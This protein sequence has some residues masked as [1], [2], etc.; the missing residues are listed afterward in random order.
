MRLRE[1]AQPGRVPSSLTRSRKPVGA[2]LA[3]ARW[4]GMRL[5]GTPSSAPF[6]GTFPQGKAICTGS[7]SSANPGAYLEPQRVQ[8]FP[9]QGP[10]GPGLNC[11]QALLVLRAGN[12]PPRTSSAS[13][14]TGVQGVGEYEH[15][16]PILSPPPA[17][18]WLLCRRGQSNP[19][20]A[21]G[22]A[23]PLQ[24]YGFFLFLRSSSTS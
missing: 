12:S 24:F 17:A 16:V 10:S 11:T 19:P 18:F 20:S 13:P 8:I 15:E 3:V 23:L 2:T 22:G 14:V 21:D 7:V 4:K 1:T 9:T 6:G 5:K